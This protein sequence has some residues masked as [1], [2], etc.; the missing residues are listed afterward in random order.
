LT[1]SEVENYDFANGAPAVGATLDLKEARSFLKKAYGRKPVGKNLYHYFMKLKLPN[2]VLPGRRFYTTNDPVMTPDLLDYFFNERTHVFEDL[3]DR[4]KALLYSIY[5]LPEYNKQMPIGFAD[6]EP[7]QAARQFQR[8]SFKFSGVFSIEMAGHTETHE[9][10]MIDCSQ[11]GFLAHSKTPVTTQVWG[12]AVL[13]LGPSEISRVR[14]LAVA[15]KKDAGFY[16]F[17]MAEPDLVWRKFVATLETG[18]THK[19]MDNATRFLRD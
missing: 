10:T 19:D 2:I 3:D 5:N 14:A 15:G 8:Y 7:E 11:R 12:D 13:R 18:T 16:G 6:S 17:K 4:E 9:L 1:E